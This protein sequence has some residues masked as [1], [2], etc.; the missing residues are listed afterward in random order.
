LNAARDE[1]LPTEVRRIDPN[2]AALPVLYTYFGFELPPET[3][4]PTD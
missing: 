1:N 3:V 4:V 2:R